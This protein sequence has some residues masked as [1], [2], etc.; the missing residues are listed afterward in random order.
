MRDEGRNDA[1]E[2]EKKYKTAVESANEYIENF[3]ILETITN[4]GNDEVFTPRKTCEMI[5]DS[6]PEEVWHNP[7]YKW[8]NP[9]TKNGVFEREIAIRLDNGL[10]DIIPDTETRRKHIL[11]NM[12]FAIGQTRFTANVARRTLYYCSEAN[13]KCDGI[14]AE[15]GHYVNG[16]AIGNGT[17][18]NDEEGN[19]KTPNT[20]HTFID[21][22]GNVMPDSCV[23]NERKKYRCE[24]CGI[25]GNSSY[26]DA[27]Q[28]ETYA[29]EF[30]HFSGD[31]LLR[32]LQDRFFGG[33]RNMKFDVVI[34]NP[35]YQL[36]DGG[37]Q[38][39]AR[40]IY[41]LFVQQSILL[42]PKY[43]CLIMPS[44]WMVGGK[45]LD[46]FRSSFIIDKHIKT[47]NDFRESKICF[48]SNDIKGGICFFLW[49]RDYNDKC[50]VIT[51]SINGNKTSLRF[52]K[53]EN[54]DIYIRDE[55]LISIMKKVKLLRELT[56]DSM[57]SARKPYGLEAET[58][59]SPKKFGLPEFSSEKMP[60]GYE[61]LG[62][63]EKMKRTWK[64]LPKDYPFP[65][66]SPCL[67]KYKVFIAE[68]YGSGILGEVPSTPILAVPGQLCTE[69]FLEIGPFDTETEAE[70]VIKYI[71]TRFFR[72]LVG[73]QKQTQH[74]TQKVYRFV[75]IQLFANNSNINWNQNIE[76]I[77]KQLFKKYN[78]S[79]DEVD[80]IEKNIQEMK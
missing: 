5:L 31:K 74:T 63:G 66:K 37:A 13:R 46:D 24:Y 6:L 27:S 3:D 26:N 79:K 57:V 68:A 67:N 15:D 39:S 73:I 29:Y 41:Q 21:A 45:G 61:I 50:T 23:E 35:P 70:N 7:N 1:L 58:M 18:F 60:E 49:D 2:A 55:I 76:A 30:I 12:I 53:E 52:L 44:R 10:K 71:K 48:P 43:I 20:N 8:L 65:K 28:R 78:L 72:V 25:N 80:F 56:F 36:S 77:D 17:W 47:L 4:V 40:P 59:L 32:H 14:K 33:N 16:Y 38:A 69:T 62:L 34:G 75:P 9:A 19:I 42:N 54:C 64:Y 51:H 22:N 11:Q